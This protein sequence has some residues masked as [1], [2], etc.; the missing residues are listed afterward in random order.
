M[1][2]LLAALLA[3]A[4]AAAQDRVKGTASFG[5]GY[6]S[7]GG[8]GTWDLGEPGGWELYGSGEAARSEPASRSRSLSLGAQHSISDE[9]QAYGGLSFW[10]DPDAEFRSVGIDAGAEVPLGPL[11]VSVDFS[12]NRYV[13][14]VVQEART[15]Q[16]RRR[17]V[18]LPP[19]TERLRLWEFHPNATVSLPLFEGKVTPSLYGGRTFYTSN[20]VAVYDRIGD[21]EFARNSERVADHVG[22]FQ[23][24]DAEAAL[25][26][27]L[28]FGLGLR[29]GLGAER[30]VLDGEW[31]T[32][33][34][35]SLSKSL[36]PAS[37]SADWNRSV[38][39]GERWDMWTLGLEW[40]F[41]ASYDDEE[42]EEADGD[43]E[44][45]EDGEDS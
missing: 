10:E 39:Y 29:A 24:H 18:T 27:E 31:T 19:V 28:P 23:S 9:S 2:L 5:D 40:K 45:D 41:G 8:E 26:L 3:A 7:W 34:S 35:L 14:D 33:R 20:P 42:P 16:R 17:A 25:D 37:V 44:Q 13:S 38:S 11:S 4:P 32:N 12:A 21:L 36:G 43:E 6:R 30:M 22:G 15:V 1:T